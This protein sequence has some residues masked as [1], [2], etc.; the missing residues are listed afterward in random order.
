M[1]YCPPPQFNPVMW[2]PG[3]GRGYLSKVYGGLGLSPVK[4]QVSAIWSRAEKMENYVFFLAQELGPPLT[5]FAVSTTQK[6]CDQCATRGCILHVCRSCFL[7]LPV[8]D[9][10][11]HPKTES[12]MNPWKKTNVRI[13]ADRL[14]GFQCWLT[15]EEN[16]HLSQNDCLEIDYGMLTS[17]LFPVFEEG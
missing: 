2:N 15:E 14:A 4:T 7:S 5:K 9:K 10:K 1:F 13:V 16:H 12:T 6:P 8:T 3:G 17:C 11:R